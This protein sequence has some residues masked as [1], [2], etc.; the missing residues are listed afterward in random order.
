MLPIFTARQQ[1]VLSA[2]LLLVTGLLLVTSASV[3]Y[4]SNK[5]NA[6]FYFGLR[7]AVFV[8]ISLVGAVAAA[9]IP[10]ETWQ[11]FTPVLLLGAVVL[12]AAVLIP[13]V[14]RE[15]NGSRRWIPLVVL[16]VQPS[17]FAKL[18]MLVFM[19]DYL[20]RRR[21]ELA[22]FATIAKPLLVMSLLL[23]LLLAEPDLG[24]SVVLVSMVFA[25]LFLAGMPWKYVA[26]LAVV[27]VGAIVALILTNPYRLARLTSYMDPWQH[28]FDSGYQLTQSL[29]AFG[30]GEW[31]GVGLGNSVQ[32]LFYLPEAHTD[33]VFAVAAEEFGLLGVIV[34][35]SLFVLLVGATLRIARD[36]ALAGDAFGAYIAWGAAVL[37]GVQAFINMGVNMGLMPTKG[38]TLPLVS[39]G[40][41]SLLANCML[42]GALWQLSAPATGATRTTR[43]GRPAREAV[44]A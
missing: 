5:L 14:G 12:L 26:G 37:F 36:R 23:V 24:T 27:G 38:L 15:V 41:S 42:L 21:E 18:A 44:T 22:S 33:F 39:Y 3:Y 20:A 9:R 34:I 6:P 25:L 8:L 28:Q 31:F 16:N 35:V 2:A 7:H 43:P 11:R 30:R 13:G 1:L 19:A 40:G 29:I 17:E 32:K 4:A 10:L